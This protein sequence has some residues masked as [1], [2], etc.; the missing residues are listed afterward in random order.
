MNGPVTQGGTFPPEEGF[1]PRAFSRWAAPPPLPLVS[2][3]ISGRH[4]LPERLAPCAR[5]LKAL[6]SG[7]NGRKER[8]AGFQVG[9]GEE[10]GVAKVQ[11]VRD[12]VFVRVVSPG[13][14][15]A[16][17]FGE[18]SRKI[19]QR[20]EAASVPETVRE[21]HPGCEAGPDGL[22]REK[23]GDPFAYAPV[24]EAEVADRE[25]GNLP[26]GA[27]GPVCIGLP[28]G[29]A[30]VLSVRQTL[31]DTPGAVDVRVVSEAV[32]TAPEPERVPPAFTAEPGE[33]PV[34]FAMG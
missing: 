3:D 10:S 8:P 13:R 7:F 20:P 27:V 2:M 24:F 9:K 16:G 25:R 30:L 18:Q 12:V 31:H 5:V 11:V 14:F 1:P 21:A 33:Q 34:H 22:P 6:K 15:G 29:A 17:Y 23:A 28:P 19:Q 26:R 4:R 32:A